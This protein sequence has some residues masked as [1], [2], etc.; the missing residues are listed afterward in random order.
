MALGT[1][2]LTIGPFAA[3]ALAM[4]VVSASDEAA[5]AAAPGVAV[6]RPDVAAL[7][8]ISRDCLANLSK[9]PFLAHPNIRACNQAMTEYNPRTCQAISPGNYRVPMQPK[10]GTIR[11]E[12]I[13]P[14]PLG[15]GDCPGH[16]FTFIMSTYDWTNADT[17]ACTSAEECRDNFTVEWYTPDD[18][19]HQQFPMTATLVKPIDFRQVGPGVP[20]HGVLHFEYTFESTSG[21]LADLSDWQVGELV[22]YPGHVNPF[23]WPR[24]PYDGSTTNPTIIWQPATDGVV[25]DDQSHVGFSNPPYRQNIFIAFQDYRYKCSTCNRAINFPG[26]TDI[27]IERKV[28][29]STGHG[30][31]G[32][33]VSKTG[34]SASVSPLPGVPPKDCQASFN[35]ETMTNSKEND[36][37]IALSVSPPAGSASLNAPIF[38]DL[39][40]LN[41]SEDAVELD[42]GLNRKTNLGLTIWSP[43]GGVTIRAL[44]ASGFGRLGEL[45]LP[46]Q[47]A[48][49]ERLLLNEWYQP[50]RV[51]TYRIRVTLL[52]A[53]SRGVANAAGPSADFAVDV[54]PRDPGQVG[55]A[56]QQLA[57]S[58]VAGARVEERMEAA[59]ALSYILDPAAVPSLVRVLEQGGSVA[60]QAV[61]GLARIGNPEATAAL[62]AAQQD[63]DEAV[64]AEAGYMLELLRRGAPAVVQP[65]D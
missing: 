33:T 51:G 65:M 49:T 36:K 8:P 63:P 22:Q 29:D 27:M 15:N 62:V 19:F 43:T 9:N 46:P 10:D 31:F 3:V 18:K 52:A 23:K 24:P 26:R 56:A 30:C 53:S 45:S 47:S 54:G 6:A 34:Y 21:D 20:R 25:Q 39:T 2:G 55:L 50:R 13:G 61:D 64:R 32:Y 60:P 35:V 4:F 48:F 7:G 44:S 40:I 1:R 37:P 41:Q 17:N 16:T 12:L 11:T 38:F 57:D 42:L 59:H 58:A 14:Y 28:S 5:A